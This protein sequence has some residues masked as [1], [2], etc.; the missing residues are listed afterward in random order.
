MNNFLFSEI[1]VIS[2]VFNITMENEQDILDLLKHTIRNI[3]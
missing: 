1:Y 3:V 2:S